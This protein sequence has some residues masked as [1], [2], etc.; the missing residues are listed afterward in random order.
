MDI[1]VTTEN[2]RGKETLVTTKAYDSVIVSTI[3]VS[4]SSAHN[5]ETLVFK[6]N[7]IDGKVEDMNE[8]DIMTYRTLIES[9]KGHKQMID[10]WQNETRD[11]SEIKHYYD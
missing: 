3:Y 11:I 8:Y 4:D 5:Y 2:E 7:M 6:V 10:K 9:K 1:S